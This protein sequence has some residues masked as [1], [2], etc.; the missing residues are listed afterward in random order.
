MNVF[1][2]ALGAGTPRPAAAPLPG[3]ARRGR[4][5]LRASLPPR[6]SSAPTAALP[7]LA[8]TRDLRATHITLWHIV[9]EQ[10]FYWILQQKDG[11]FV[12]FTH[13]TKATALYQQYC[14]L[15]QQ[16]YAKSVE[17]DKENQFK[18]PQTSKV[19]DFSSYLSFFP[20]KI[21]VLNWC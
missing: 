6:Q 20:P 9:L 8:G 17:Q 21:N 19:F 18:L 11:G 4:S 14:S 16:N 10:L 1:W 12:L 7:A 5:A 13:H 3:G 2:A 15:C